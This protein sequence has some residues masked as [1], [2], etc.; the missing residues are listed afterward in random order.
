MKKI[1]ANVFS[2]VKHRYGLALREIACDFPVILDVG[3]YTARSQIVGEFFKNFDYKSVN[4]GSAW[5][6]NVQADYIYDGLNLPFADSSFD[7]VISVDTLE[8]VNHKD[9]QRFI[10]EIKRV[11][12]KRAVIVTPFRMEGAVTDE[13]YVLSVCRRFDA[14]FVPSLAEHEA[15]GLP[16][17]DFLKK[18]TEENHGKIKYATVRKDYW[19]LQTAMLWNSLALGED[20]VDINRRL[21]AFQERMLSAQPD[22]KTPEEA[23]RCVLVFDKA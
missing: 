23:Y 6:G 10:K 21:Q 4:V 5:Y 8:H 20:S 13:S 14:E 3:G 12:R 15:M 9:R 18:I 16:V 17:I 1:A 22:P 19:S 7:Y 11:A 2:P